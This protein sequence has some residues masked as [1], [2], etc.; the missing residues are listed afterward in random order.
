[1]PHQETFS[2]PGLDSIF[3]AKSCFS[4]D[5]DHTVSSMQR[6]AF[7]KT[8]TIQCLPCKELLFSKPGPYSV[9]HAKS[10]FQTERARLC[11]AGQ[12]ESAP[13][14]ILGTFYPFEWGVFSGYIKPQNMWIEH[15]IQT[16]P[17]FFLCIHYLSRGTNYPSSFASLEPRM[18]YR[19]VKSSVQ[20]LI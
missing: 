2:R 18:L 7:L 4:Q 20:I 5:L 10:C 11:N 19:S 12:G 14:L 9:F 15:I 13:T 6:A 1:M 17:N 16:Y 8:W 3:H